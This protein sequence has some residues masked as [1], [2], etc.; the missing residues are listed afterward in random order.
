MSTRSGGD[1]TAAGGGRD[2]RGSCC[3]TRNFH[4]R[5]RWARWV[6]KGSQYIPDTRR[7]HACP[8]FED[9]SRAHDEVR[10]VEEISSPPTAQKSKKQQRKKKRRER[11]D[12]RERRGARRT[13]SNLQEDVEDNE[14]PP[15]EAVEPLSPRRKSARLAGIKKKNRWF[16]K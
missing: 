4:S 10:M 14:E 3:T 7:E 13:I 8:D 11:D 6:S 12:G 2:T 5:A 1:G 9:V 15:A 16:N